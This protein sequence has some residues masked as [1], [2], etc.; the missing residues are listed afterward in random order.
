MTQT[1]AQLG[2]DGYLLANGHN[3]IV[4]IFCNILKSPRV[5]RIDS[6]SINVDIAEQ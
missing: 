3:T 5:Y 6:V 4:E 2:I 1:Q